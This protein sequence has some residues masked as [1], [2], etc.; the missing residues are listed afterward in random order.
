MVLP[1]PTSPCTSRFMGAP[2]AVSTAT[3]SMARRWAAVREKGSS[4][5]NSSTGGVERGRPP[6]RCAGCAAGPCRRPGRTAPRR[7]AAAGPAPGP[8]RPG[9]VDVPAGKLGGGQGRA[10]AA[11]RRE[12]SP[13]SARRTPPRSGG[14]AP[15]AGCWRS[16][17]QGI[18]GQ[19]TAGEAGPVRPLTHR[20]GHLTPPRR[21][22]PPG[23]RRRTSRRCA[24]RPSYRTG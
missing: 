6:H 19:D 9:E 21:D 13:P 17:G 18:D 4:A 11:V 12:A 10:P 8:P 22:P 23:R 16:P 14:S 1:E 24:G 7:S 20:V 5:R 15:P 3:S 2:E